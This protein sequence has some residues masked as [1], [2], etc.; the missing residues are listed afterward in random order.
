MLSKLIKHEFKATYR[1]FLPIYIGLV[2]IT[3]LACATSILDSYQNTLLSIALGFGMIIF[4]L[5]YIFVI[6]SP[7]IFLPIRFYRTTATREAYLTFTVPADTKVILLAKFIVAFAWSLITILLWVA[8]LIIFISSI[9]GWDWRG[10]AYFFDIEKEYLIW[11][12]LTMITGL[13]VNILSI[14]AAISL[15]QLVRDH[16]VIASFAFY[17]AIYTVQ[18]II[19]VCV[20]IPFMIQNLNAVAVDEFSRGMTSDLTSSSYEDIMIY[21]LSLAVSLGVSAA[22]FFLSNH[23]LKKKL[24]L[25]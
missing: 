2:I 14:F 19:S 15:S 11:K 23:M 3:G 20:L 8:T 4:V 7:F 12:I 10:L 6:L 1:I 17:A 24:N 22:C 25:L 5:G 21:I 13:A 9:D 18:Q 16:R